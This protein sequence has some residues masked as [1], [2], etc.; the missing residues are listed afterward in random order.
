MSRKNDVGM[1]T[2]KAVYRRVYDF[3]SRH[4]EGYEDDDIYWHEVLADLA[5]FKTPLEIEMA[6]VV[7]NELER[8]YFAREGVADGE[9]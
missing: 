3:H 7:V 8:R 2:L 1:E 5:G 6:V 4:V 9:C